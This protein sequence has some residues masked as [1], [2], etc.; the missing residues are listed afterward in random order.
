MPLLTKIGLYSLLINVLSL[1]FLIVRNVSLIVILKFVNDLKNLLE[2]FL[3]ITLPSLIDFI[4][5][6]V[7]EFLGTPANTDLMEK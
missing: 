5:S 1:V 7:N 6:K 4:S 3:I 2:M